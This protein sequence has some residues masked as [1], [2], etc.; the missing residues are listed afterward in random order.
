MNTYNVFSGASSFDQNLGKWYV[1]LDSTGIDLDVSGDTIGTISA[2]NSFLDGQVEYG[3]GLGGNPDLF[4]INSASKTLELNP[5][6]N[7]SGGTYQVNI[8]STGFFGT[9]SHRMVDVIMTGSRDALQPPPI[10]TA[11]AGPDQIVNE[12]DLV[13]LSGLAT[14]SGNG[15][16]TY[17]WTHDSDLAITLSD[18]AA[19][20]AT[21]TAPAVTSDTNVTFTLTVTDGP[22]TVTDNVIVTIENNDPPS[23][24]AGTDQTVLEGA[25]VTLAGTATDDGSSLTYGWTHD[26]DL[27]ITLSDS[28]ALTATFTAPAVDADTE[29]TFTLTV[30]DGPNTVTD[31]VI[32]TIENNGSPTV[33]AGTDQT[34][35]E[36]ATVTL[37][38]TATDDGSSLTY[39]WTHDSDLAITLSDSAALT[40]TFTAPAVTSDTNVTF[41][42]TVTDGPNTVTDN[43]IVTIE[44]ND[45]PSIDAGTDQ[46]VLEGATVTLAGTATDDGSSL[47]YGWTHDSDLAIT[48]SDSAALTAT[49][50]AP[51][52]T[53][54]TNVT[55][56]LTVTDGP[57]TVTDNVIVTIE[58]NGS[59]TVSAGTDQTVLEGATVTLAGTATDDGSSLTYGWTH[60]S[61]MEISFN[62]SSPVVAFAAPQVD[63]DTTVTFTLTVSDGSANS[64]DTVLVTVSDVPDDTDFVTT[65]ETTTP[66]DSITIPA[67]GTYAIDWGDGT[68]DARVRGEQTHTYADAGNHTVRISEGITAIYLNDHADAPKLRSIDQWGDAE[69]ESMYSS[70]RGAS[71]MILY[72]TDAPDLSR[73]KDTRGCCIIPP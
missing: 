14:Y 69:W 41:T 17:A 34:V 21:F 52:V 71:K 35:L 22:N 68:V 5:Y 48:L 39:G 16:I 53:S 40:A 37:A 64:T 73:V 2:Q 9:D 66:G 56:T 72:A 63:A 28:A 4:L 62:A 58:N 8:T 15:T 51:A 54:D 20:T 67:R 36:G 46:T 10:V 23:I 3:I 47:T 25:T 1:T 18:S 59:P 33:S 31:N 27:A 42:L 7:H 43:V 30:T 26:S 38:G 44:N 29:V 49:F 11:N 61:T 13:T 45:P 55:F 57:N 19:L 32:V 70:F 6:V 65:W 50:T 60:D 12:E 24:D